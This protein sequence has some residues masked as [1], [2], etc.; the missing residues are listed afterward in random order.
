MGDTSLSKLHSIDRPNGG[1]KLK[2]L[3]EFLVFCILDTSCTYKMVCRTFDELRACDMTT[4]KGIKRFTAKQIE[5]RLKWA[6]YRFPTQHARRIKV[7]GSNN[8]NLKTATRE[9]LVDN[10]NGIG[11]K[12]ASFFL[13]NTRGEDHAVLDVHTLRWLQKEFKIPDKKFKRMSYE[14]KEGFFKAAAKIEG[15]STMELDLEIWT[16]MRVGNNV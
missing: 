15:K 13:R 6:G 12:L 10:I 9:E 11:L 16:K 4:R 5:A 7:F 3:D 2:D 14:T 1:Y 8:I